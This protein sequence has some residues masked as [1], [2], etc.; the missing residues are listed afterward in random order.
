MDKNR[1]SAALEKLKSDDKSR[2]NTAK[3][4]DL[5]DVI[6]TAISSGISLEAIHSELKKEGLDQTFYSFKNSLYRIRK[7]SL[8][9]PINQKTDTGGAAIREP[10]EPSPTTTST[11]SKKSEREKV[12]NHFMQASTTNPLI[13]RHLTK[14]KNDENSSD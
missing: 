10:K 13:K 5:I 6:E 12:A 7:P 2:S 4:R 8:N 3:I 1:I 9:K 11:T 14:G